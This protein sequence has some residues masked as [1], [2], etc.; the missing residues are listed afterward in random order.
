MD[1]KDNNN[2][3]EEDLSKDN[4][5]HKEDKENHKKEDLII[6]RKEKVE[7][8]IMNDQKDLK[9]QKDRV[10]LKDQKEKNNQE[11]AHKII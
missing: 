7:L 4:I 6:H 11:L 1:S 3:N 2:L 9:Y 8:E 10:G 5:K